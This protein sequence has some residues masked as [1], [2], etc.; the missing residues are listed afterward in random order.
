MLIERGRLVE[1]QQVVGLLKEEEYSQFVRRGAGGADAGA[2][3]AALTPAEADAWKRYGEV[4]DRITARGRR[5]SELLSKV[6][7]TPDDDRQ[8]AEIDSELAVAGQ[9][10]QGF[11]D[12]LSAELG[13]TKQAARVEQVRESRGLMEDLRELG[14]DSVALYTLV[15][16]ERYR[17]VLITPDTQVAREYPIKASELNKKVAAFREVLQRPSADPRPLA[18]ELYQIIVGPV[19]RDLKQARA[20]TLMW[21]LDGALRYVPVAALYDGAGYMVERYRNVVFT[22]AST[23]R[24][25]DEPR[26]GWKALGFGVSKAFRRSAARNYPGGDQPKQNECLKE[27]AKLIYRSAT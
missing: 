15:G 4:A 11:L 8:L 21:S 7:R 9:A 17:V 1:A 3:A 18:Q 12:R 5:R 24:L 22:P 25:K 23:A 2:K 6:N 27:V 20:E 16:E 13:D 14:A 19:A 10:F 26:A